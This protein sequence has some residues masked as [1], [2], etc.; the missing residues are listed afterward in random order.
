MA[1]V[2]LIKRYNYYNMID[3]SSEILDHGPKL[4]MFVVV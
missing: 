4:W 1:S 3:S 2:H